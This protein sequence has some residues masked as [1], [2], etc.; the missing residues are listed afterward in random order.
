MCR[1]GKLPGAALTAFGL[2]I[3]LSLV[4]GSVFISV[5]LGIA[6]VGIGV[7]LLLKK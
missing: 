1:Y 2:G 4:I 7:W 6:A 3:L 5:L